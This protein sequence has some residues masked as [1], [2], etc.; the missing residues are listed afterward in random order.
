MEKFRD[1]KLE[2]QMASVQK[3]VTMG[4]SLRN[5][6]NLK[7][8]QPLSSVALVTRD[9]QEKSVLE[10]MKDTIA[11]ELNVK[12]VVFHDQEADLVEYKA[13]ANFKV[14][15]KLLGSK[16]KSVAAEIL[17]LEDSQIAKIVDGEEIKIT[18]DGD[19]IYDESLSRDTDKINQTF[20]AKGNVTIKV[21]IS[22]SIGSAYILA[23]KKSYTMD[24][25]SE[26]RV[27]TVE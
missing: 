13:K 9:M 6:F 12:S 16:M 20:E 23:N 14:L 25:N 21:Y 1:E 19:S 8:R 15:G 5:Q 27:L 7:N 4:R 11:E 22:D 3:A 24:M 10:S 26:N 2:F 18:V 17:K